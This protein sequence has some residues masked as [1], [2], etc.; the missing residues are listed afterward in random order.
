MPFFSPGY[1]MPQWDKIYPGIQGLE[2]FTQTIG[3]GPGKFGKKLTKQLWGGDY[4][5]IAG[6]LLSPIQDQFRTNTREALR[7][8]MMGGNALFQGSQPALMSAIEQD[9]RRKMA[10]AQGLALGQAIPQLW[11]SA[12]E[13]WQRGLDSA[14]NAEIAA[15]EAALRGRIAASQPI[16]TPSTWDKITGVIGGLGAMI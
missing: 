1:K 16:Q 5:G 2:D 15:R 8:N 10:E 6:T 7:A 4:S 13:T 14:R 9:T 3:L 11:S 12:T